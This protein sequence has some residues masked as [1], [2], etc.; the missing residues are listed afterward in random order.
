M[1][2]TPRKPL[3]KPFSSSSKRFSL[4][5][6]ASPPPPERAAHE[7]QGRSPSPAPF[8]PRTFS[9]MENRI[10]PLTA[11][12]CGRLLGKQRIGCHL[13]QLGGNTVTFDDNTVDDS[14]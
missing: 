8:P 4:P 5:L 1:L 3:P 12:I 14:S 10:A 9:L 2:G 11:A 6:A 13:E 7:F